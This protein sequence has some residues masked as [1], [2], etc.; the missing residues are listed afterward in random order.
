MTDNNQLIVATYNIQFAI[1]TTTIVNSIKKMT[2][3][4]V[5]V[6]CLQELVNIPNDDLMKRILDALGSHWKA[7]YHVGEEMSR[8]SIGTGIIWDSTKIQLVDERK[9]LLPK[10]KKYAPHER[11]YYKLINVPPIP[12][13][14]RATVCSFLFN[15]APLRI[16]CVHVD[17]VGGPVQRRRQ[18]KHLISVLKGSKTPPHE[19]ICGDFNTFDLLRT[20]YEKQMIQKLLGKDFVDASEGAGWTSDIYNID[21]HDSVKIFP[22]FIKTFNVHIRSRLDYIWTKNFDVLSCEKQRLPGSDH[23]PLIAKLQLK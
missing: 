6:F 16:T 20:G 18:L 12:L 3:K 11:L 7:S 1:N 23:F 17:N 14:R 9:I 8:L 22:W 15:K 13:Q 10:L 2:E 19:V 4:G 21:F 5:T